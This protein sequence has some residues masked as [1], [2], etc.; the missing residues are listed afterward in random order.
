VIVLDPTIRLP[1]CDLPCQLWFMLNHFHTG[2]GQC[3]ASSYKWLIASSKMS[4]LSGV[5]YESH[6][7]VMSTDQTCWWLSS[8][9]VLHHLPPPSQTSQHYSLRPKQHNLKLSVGVT[10]LTDR[11]FVLRMLH[12]DSY[13][14]NRDIAPFSE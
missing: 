13:W 8:T 11:N 2:Q 3:A 12:M 6:C 1:A 10:S 5:C 9:A 14:P 7:G 4:M